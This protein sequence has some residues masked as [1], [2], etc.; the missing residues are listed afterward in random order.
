VN[1][2]LGLFSSVCFFDVLVFVLLYFVLFY[3]YPIQAHL[4]SNERQKGSGSGWERRWG[5]PA[6]SKG[7]ETCNQDILCWGG[8]NASFNKGGKNG[9]M[10]QIS[11]P[12]TAKCP[13]TSQA[14]AL[15]S[16]KV[17]G[18][19]AKGQEVRRWDGGEGSCF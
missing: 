5:G 4:F 8:G 13:E 3:Y 15:A 7:R 11:C 1:L 16:Q 6:R 14:E 18:Q 12:H 17:S 9:Q 19:E 10:Q 2:F